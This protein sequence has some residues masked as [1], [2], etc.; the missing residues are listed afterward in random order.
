MHSHTH[1]HR[2]KV[3]YTYTYT[4]SFTHAHTKSYTHRLE[5]TDTNGVA[6]GGDASSGEV[7]GHGG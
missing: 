3:I 6:R 2:N 5:V 1:G 4:L 7:I